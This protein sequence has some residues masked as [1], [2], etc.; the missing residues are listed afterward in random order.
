VDLLHREYDGCDFCL[1][2][3]FWVERVLKV[4]CDLGL[5][6]HADGEDCR[7]VKYSEEACDED[8]F[9][10]RSHSL[11]QQKLANNPRVRL[12]QMHVRVQDE[13]AKELLK[14]RALFLE[15]EKIHGNFCGLF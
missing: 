4:L 5:G 10:G 12:D 7:V 2:D 1:C 15:L 13:L 14:T 3:L 8:A 11:L 9:G 6:V